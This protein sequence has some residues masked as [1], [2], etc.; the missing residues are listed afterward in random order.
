MRAMEF[1]NGPAGRESLYGQK[2]T[3]DYIIKN[4]L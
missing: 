2:Q 1:E 3:E 4:A